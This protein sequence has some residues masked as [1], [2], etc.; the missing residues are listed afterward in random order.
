MVVCWGAFSPLLAC[1]GCLPAYTW[2]ASILTQSLF[3]EMGW[4]KA[5]V[6]F[7]VACALFLSADPSGN[8]PRYT[9]PL[10]SEKS[11]YL[12]RHGGLI[13]SSAGLLASDGHAPESD[14]DQRLLEKSP[15]IGGF[16]ESDAGVR[17]AKDSAAFAS[18]AWQ[19]TT[20][21][22]GF[23]GTAKLSSVAAWKPWDEPNCPRLS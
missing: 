7:I 23:S 10:A 20:R 2:R 15:S 5:I 14:P 6:V 9:A 21:Q 4:R 3:N 16:S 13:F 19:A 1:L 8:V 18:G 12:S 17:S 22:L 11:W